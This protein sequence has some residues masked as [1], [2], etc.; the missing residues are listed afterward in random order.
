MKRTILAHVGTS[1]FDA[2][3]FTRI[4]PRRKAGELKEQFQRTPGYDGKDVEQAC[5]DALIEG[6]KDCWRAGIEPRK[7]RHESPAEIAS[8]HMIGVQPG[9]RVVLVSSDTH[10]GTFCAQLLRECLNE[11]RHLPFS[12]PDLDVP[13][14]SRLT[15]VETQDGQAFV[16]NGL[17][18]Y[19]KLIA[20]ERKNLDTEP[21]TQNYDHVPLLFNITGG[22]KGLIPFAMIAAQ[23][24][25]SHPHYNIATKLVYYYHEGAHFIEVNTFFPLD[26]GKLRDI[27]P[28]IEHM[29]KPGGNT[30]ERVP[31]NDKKLHPY[32][33]ESGQPNAL[34]YALYYLIRD[35]KWIGS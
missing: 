8:L 35:L 26:W 20:H 18:A 32:C 28:R 24:L 31:H 33:D 14:V 6:L 15:G 13:P 27:Y 11:L 22:Y 7:S 25:A 1:L 34:A 23:L 9:D 30:R 3:A 12:T 10:A 2:R 4:Y 5:R 16:A 21:G 29:C 17:P 19:M